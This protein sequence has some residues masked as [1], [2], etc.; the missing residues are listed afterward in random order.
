[1]VG[2][3]LYLDIK[4]ARQEGLSTIFINNKG[5]VTDPTIGIVVDSVEDISKELIS[6]IEQRNFEFER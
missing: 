4:R 3:D 2:D 6:K 5:V 1:M